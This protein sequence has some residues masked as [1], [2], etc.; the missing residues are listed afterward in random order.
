MHKLEYKLCKLAEEV[1]KLDK[2]LGEELFLLASMSHD[3]V[4]DSVK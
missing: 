4:E 3:Y 2:N 1:S